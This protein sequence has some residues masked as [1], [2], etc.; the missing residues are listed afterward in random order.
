MKLRRTD[1]PLILSGGLTPENVAAAIAATQPFAVDVASGT[2]ASPGVKDPAKLR[3][4]AEAV[5]RRRGGGLERG[6]GADPRT[7]TAP[8]AASTSP[9]R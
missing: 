2:E 8:T 9:R 7:A 5:A 6:R 1:V 3:A 4:F